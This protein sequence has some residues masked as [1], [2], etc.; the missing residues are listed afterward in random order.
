MIIVQTLLDFSFAL[1]N[2]WKTIFWLLMRLF[3]TTH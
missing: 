2:H 3:S 1:K